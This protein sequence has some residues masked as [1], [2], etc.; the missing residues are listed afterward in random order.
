[1]RR[2]LDPNRNCGPLVTAGR[3]ALLVDG[4]N[5][6]GALAD[7]ITKA[8]RTVL[9]VGWDL[10]SRAR[11]GPALEAAHSMPPLRE[12]LPALAA[13]NPDLDI[14]L[15]SWNFSML[16]AGERDPQLVFGQ[17]PFRHPRVHLHF[18]DAHPSGASHHQK[19][20]VID[21]CLAFTGGMDIAGGRWDTPEHRGDDSRRSGKDAPYPPSHDVQAVVD[22]DAARALARIARERWR[23]S[24]GSSIPESNQAGDIWPADVTPDL[25]D[26]RIGIS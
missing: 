11:L 22:G 2:L 20:V 17:N 16:F 12:F 21:D 25:V 24:T 15:L 7:S 18:D 6:Y 5:Y 3:F 13:R 26:V 9:I 14:Y 10:D 19:I 8:R 23:R 1:M 4:S